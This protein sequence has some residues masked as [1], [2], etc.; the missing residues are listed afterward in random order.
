VDSAHLITSLRSS[1]RI[2]AF[3]VEKMPTICPGVDFD[4][5]A[6][7]WRCKWSEDSEKKS[8]EEVQ[9][10]L[11]ETMP[12]I[13]AVKGVKSVQ[14]VVCGGCHDFKV[15]TSMKAGDNW[16]A[17]EKAEFAPEADF[18][19]AIKA[20]KGVAT[21][22]TQTYTL[23]PMK[24]V[25]PPKL[26]KAKM[27]QVGKLKPEQ[28]GFTVEVKVLDEPTAVERGGKGGGKLFEVPAGDATGKVTL[29]LKEGQMEGVKKD[30]V[31]VLRNASVIMV[32]GRIRLAVDKWGK[33]DLTSEEKIEEIGEKNV[34]ELEFE[35]VRAK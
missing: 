4:T 10:I 8:L 33:I 34:S 13:S 11:T 12:K 35:L 16:E 29:S 7:E 3:S 1:L 31:L 18:L 23:A 2:L 28:K 9:K 24:V 27:F 17:W 21:V 19:A 15:I 14:R 6:R 5:L 32:K 25:P 30:K 20:I 22:E 26:K